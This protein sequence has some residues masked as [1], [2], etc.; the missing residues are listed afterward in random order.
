MDT[1]GFEYV[2]DIEWVVLWK[3]LDAV[4]VLVCCTA[5]VQSEVQGPL[6]GVRVRWM[7]RANRSAY[8][9]A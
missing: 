8:K 2:V 9:G 6:R 1:E 5:N 7:G 3:D 4:Y